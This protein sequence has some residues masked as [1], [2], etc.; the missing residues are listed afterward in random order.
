MA[1]LAYDP[2]RVPTPPTG[3]A[4]LFDPQY[5][6]RITL[7]N[8]FRDGLGM[9]MLAGGDSPAAPTAAALGRAADLVRAAHAGGQFA[10]FTPP[11]DPHA[12][13]VSGGV[14]LA[15]VRSGDL[16]RLRLAAPG[17][18]FTIPGAGTTLSAQNMVIPGGAH[19]RTAGE[20]WMNW[21]YEPRRY[22][23]LIAG[24][25]A[26]SVQAGLDDELARIDPALA[27]DPVLNPGA[28]LAQRLVVWA[29]LAP[30]VDARYAQLY[31][32]A[33]A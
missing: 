14:A 6:G 33:T 25:R 2:A 29:P 26:T 19:N 13:L 8:D 5:R 20:A 7:L 22:A 23:T 27:A 16:P 31:A 30:A 12:D 3:V 32:S 4:D 21:L 28:G 9:I 17:L 18:A 24:L 10:R 1:G 11:D 15:Q